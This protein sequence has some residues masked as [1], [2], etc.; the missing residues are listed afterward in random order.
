[1]G[2]RSA[3]LLLV[4]LG[5]IPVCIRR[6][7]IGFLLWVW[8]GV[9][10]PHTLTWGLAASLPL[11]LIVGAATLVGFLV[12]PDEK[13]WKG[14]PEAY[15]LLL[16]FLW[17]CVTTPFAL[18]P[19]EAWRLWELYAKVVLMTFLGLLVLNDRRQV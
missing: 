13:H 16:F 10:A 11:S 9:M 7:Y 1:M 3:L 18:N 19:P 4:V 15:A 6:P 8:V 14:R 5:S 17:T 2:I 12:S